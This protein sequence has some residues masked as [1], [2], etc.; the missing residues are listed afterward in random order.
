MRV[1]IPLAAGLSL[2][3]GNFATTGFGQVVVRHSTAPPGDLIVAKEAPRFTY[4]LFWKQQDASTQ[5]FAETLRSAGATRSGRASWRSVDVKDP[6]NRAAVDHYGVSRAP[7]PLAICVAENGAITGVFTRRP[8][9]QALERALVTP[10]MVQVTK[11]LQDKKIVIVHV[12]PTAES[13]LPNGAAELVAAP[14]FQARTTTIDVV[15]GDPTESRF[16]ADMQLSATD[17]SDSMLVVMAPPGVLVGKF[18]GS[19][20][21]E[22]IVLQLHA[23]GKCCDDPNCKHN[24]KAQ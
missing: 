20:T 12:K 10:A 14:D 1:L 18:R 13:P 9:D 21:K 8:T 24:K 2:S 6:A 23:A 4:I 11:A 7:M 17:V 22:Q 15:R 5:Q 19:A 16:L 3:F